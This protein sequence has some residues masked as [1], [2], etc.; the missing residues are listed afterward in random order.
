MASEVSFMKSLTSLSRD[1]NYIADM[2]M[3]PKFGNSSISMWQVIKTQSY[4]DLT[5]KNIFL[6][7]A[8]S[9]SSVISD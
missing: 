2:A 7:D 8:L 9:S 1:L 5:G 6:R 3:W 4:K